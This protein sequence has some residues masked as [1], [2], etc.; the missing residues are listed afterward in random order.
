MRSGRSTASSAS[1]MRIELVTT[2]RSSTAVSASARRHV[3]VP[4]VS[5]I[6]VPGRT[7]AGGGEGD[8]PLLVDLLG[9][10]DGEARLDGGRRRQR[11]AAVHL[12]HEASRVSGVEVATDGHVADPELRRQVADPRRAVALDVGGDQLPAAPGEHPR[13]TA[14]GVRRPSRTRCRRPSRASSTMRPRSQQIRSSSARWIAVGCGGLWS[15]LRDSRLDFGD[16]SGPK[17]DPRPAPAGRSSLGGY[18]HMSRSTLVARPAPSAHPQSSIGPLTRRQLLAG[19]G[20]V[21][22]GLLLGG[23]G[24]SLGIGGRAAHPGPQRPAAAPALRRRRRRARSRSAATTPT[25]C[26]RRR[27]RR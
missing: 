9:R 16:T 12:V 18:M 5:P 7:S 15:N 2:I 20:A 6:A 17:C 26:P 10:L 25:T 8:R 3:V 21:G 14:A 27:S 23:A 22:A 11:G 1:Q 24:F 4:A 19:A 13:A